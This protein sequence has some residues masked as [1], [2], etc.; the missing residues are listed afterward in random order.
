MKDTLPKTGSRCLTVSSSACFSCHTPPKHQAHG[1]EEG[2]EVRHVSPPLA[3]GELFTHEGHRA[4]LQGDHHGRR[5]RR[6]RRGGPRRGRATHRAA[7]ALADGSSNASKKLAQVE[8]KKI[9]HV[10]IRCAYMYTL[11][12]LY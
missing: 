4:I 9:R 6:A 3:E 5:G 11:L 1:L 12:S 2:A 7:A 10:S 8:T